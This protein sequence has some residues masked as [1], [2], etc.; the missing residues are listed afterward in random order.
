MSVWSIIVNYKTAP[1]AVRA[2]ESLLDAGKKLSDHNFTTI[3]DNN[4][5]DGSVDVLTDWVRQRS[6]QETVRVIASDRNGGYGYGNNLSLRIGLESQPRPDYFYLLNPDAFPER[7]AVSKL[8]DYLDQH[9][10]VGIA[11]SFVQGTDGC[12]HKTAFRFPTVQSEFESTISLGIVTRLLKNYVVWPPIP[13]RAG[14]TQWV[15]GVSM[16]IRREVLEEIGLFDEEFFLYFE[17]VD[18]CRRARQAGWSTHYVPESVVAHVGS[19]STGY[20]QTDRPMPRWWF[21]SRRHYFQK[22]HGR[23]Y[24]WAANMARVAGMSLGELKAFLQRKPSNRHV[25]FFGDFLKHSVLG[26][27]I[28]P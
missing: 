19:A 21:D 18:L 5:Q 22:T 11:G 27:S 15:A 14:P 12:P 24:L 10:D 3:V 7:D 9:R 13:T 6:L 25:H 17:E 1:L 28:G 16:M 26:R 23:G 4:S 2:A 8:V 20:Q